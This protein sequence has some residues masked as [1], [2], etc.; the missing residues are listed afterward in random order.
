M[1]S[2]RILLWVLAVVLWPSAFVKGDQ[3]K[4]Q[5]VGIL[6]YPSVQIIDFT[7]PYEIFGWAAIRW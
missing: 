6:L 3:E 5:T 1:K 7:G 4:Q 2:M